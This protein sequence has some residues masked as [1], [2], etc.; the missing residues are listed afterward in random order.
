M[1]A[2]LE[3][4][5]QYR[6]GEK[7]MSGIQEN[8]GNPVVLK[9]EGLLRGWLVEEGGSR[10][11]IDYQAI[12]LAG[13][14]KVWLT[15]R[16]ER[17]SVHLPREVSFA[18]HDIRGSQVDPHRGAWLWSHLWMEASDGVLHQE[19]DWMREPVIGGDPVGDGDAAF[20]L[21][22]FPQDLQW[23]PEW[24]AVKAAAYHKEAERR[25]RRRQ[26]D[27]ERRARKKAE[28]A[29]AVEVTGE[30]SGSDASGRVDE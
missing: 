20:E 8:Q 5:N 3:E 11:D 13:R 25:G 30:Q 22:Q 9:F 12:H 16:G 26:R 15:R 4:V 24:M 2:M 18:M 1:V 10:V 27:R 29:G 21:D 19:C 28:V 6:I 7:L 17:K 14:V 23:V